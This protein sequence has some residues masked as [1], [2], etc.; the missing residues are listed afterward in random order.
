MTFM[1]AGE[2]PEVVGLFLK[3]WSPYFLDLNQVE[4]SFH[5]LP[6]VDLHLLSALSLQGKATQVVWAWRDRCVDKD[7][8]WCLWT[9]GGAHLTV[10]RV[11]PVLWAYL[12]ALAGHFL[13]VVAGVLSWAGK[14]LAVLAAVLTG[15]QDAG[16]R[17]KG[18]EGGV[19][20]LPMGVGL[21]I[22]HTGFLVFL[23]QDD[24]DRGATCCLGLQVVRDEAQ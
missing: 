7:P 13:G 23:L 15:T 10:A 6:E 19:P 24:L 14:A 12:A 16:Q 21:S 22:V 1:G 4:D 8:A 17:A 5:Q 18:A 3:V 2:W 20:H 9:L 11:G